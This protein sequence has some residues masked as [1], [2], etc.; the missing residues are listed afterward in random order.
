MAV[1]V[2]TELCMMVSGVCLC[3]SAPVFTTNNNLL[4]ILSSN[5]IVTT[6]RYPPMTDPL[7]ISLLDNNKDTIKFI[8]KSFDF[9][10]SRY[11]YD[12]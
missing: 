8:V 9:L 1:T 12:S 2:L 4:L 10:P 7:I 3:I 11:P 6:G 5:E